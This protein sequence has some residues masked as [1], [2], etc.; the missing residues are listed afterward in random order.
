MANRLMRPPSLWSPRFFG[1]KDLTTSYAR[2][3]AG[4]G[5]V[6]QDA[7][8]ASSSAR[9]GGRRKSRI[10]SIGHPGSWATSGPGDKA[11][12]DRL[13]TQRD[14]YAS[15]A[16]TTSAGSLYPVEQSTPHDLADSDAF[17]PVIPI[18]SG[19]PF[20]SI[21]ATQSGAFRPAIPADSGHRSVAHGRFVM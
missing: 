7:A 19:H 21:P 1:S 14:R 20:Q 15:R 3:T 6:S 16:S 5:A 18:D 9:V 12:R 11:P 2:S 17:R 8:T 10:R 4:R 13:I